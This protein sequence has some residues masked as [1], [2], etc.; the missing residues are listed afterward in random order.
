M[1]DGKEAQL[2]RANYVLRALNV[3]AGKRTIEFRFQPK[4]YTVGNKISTASSW[5]MLL[6]LVGSIGWTL[7]REN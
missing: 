1:I 6:M 4:A 3:P 7:K 5:I 2:L